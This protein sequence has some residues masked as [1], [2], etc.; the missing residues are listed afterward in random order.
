M[1]Q[2]AFKLTVPEIKA[3]CDFFC[4]DRMPADKEKN[5]DK[6]TLIDRLLDFLG[7]PDEKMLA[8]KPSASTPTP[9]AKTG[10]PKK[11]K[12]PVPK[13]KKVPAEDDADEDEN[14]LKGAT[15]KGE[16]PSDDELRAWVQAYVACFDLDK[17]TTK[18]ALQTASDKFGV[19][20]S[21]KKTRIKELLGEEM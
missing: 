13:N 12:G 3:L 9:A 19:D 11:K 6:D 5:I 18:H 1:A 2:K 8:K 4:V 17:A 14:T 7:A 10:T 15:G 20:L 21:S 16:I